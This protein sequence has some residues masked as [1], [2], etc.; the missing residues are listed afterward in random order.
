MWSRG[1]VKAILEAKALLRKGASGK[2]EE[3]ALLYARLQGWTEEEGVNTQATETELNAL[4]DGMSEREWQG[5]RTV[6]DGVGDEAF[7]GL[8]L[9]AVDRMRRSLQQEASGFEA[10]E[11]TRWPLPLSGQGRDRDR[12]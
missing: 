8:L 9:Y 1:E 2:A 5:I 4:L 10:E 3:A 12:N 6:A 7:K 11:E